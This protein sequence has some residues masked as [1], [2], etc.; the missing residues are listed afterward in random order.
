MRKKTVSSLLVIC[1][2]FT[3]TLGAIPYNTFAFSDKNEIEIDNLEG[4]IYFGNTTLVTTPALYRLVAKSSEDITL[5]YDGANIAEQEMKYDESNHNAWKDSYICNWLNGTGFI[6]KE[7][8]FTKAEKDSIIPYGE[9]EVTYEQTIDIS[10]KIVLPSYE[11]VN[12]GGAWRMNTSVRNKHGLEW[13]LRTPNKDNSIAALAVFVDGGI[14]F[15]DGLVANEYG[16]C[17]A[18][19]LKKDS[20]LLTSEAEGGKSELAKPVLETVSAANSPQKLTIIDSYDENA[21]P[22]GLK[23]GDVVVNGA[24]SNAGTAVKVTLTE[25]SS[26]KS[27]SA[28]VKNNS[29]E[30]THYGKIGETDLNGSAKNLDLTLPVNIGAGGNTLEIFVEEIN[31]AYK[32]DYASTP[33]AIEKIIPTKTKSSTSTKEESY[34]VEV[35]KTKGGNI[36]EKSLEYSNGTIKIYSILPDEGY[37]IKDVIIDN[38]SVGVVKEFRFSDFSSRHSIEAI[39][40]VENKNSQTEIKNKIQ[41]EF[42]YKNKFKDVKESDWF[43]NAVMNLSNLGLMNGTT[44]VSFEPKTKTTKAMALTILYNMSGRPAIKTSG[45]KW[46]SVPQT[47]AVVNGISDGLNMEDGISREQLITL[48]WRLEG[49]PTI[50]NYEGLM[51]F[52]DLDKISPY[53]KAAFIWAHHNGII[54]GSQDKLSPKANATRAETAAII[55]NYIKQK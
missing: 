4:N 5:F 52:K 2:L 41:N 54:S 6:D 49:S 7:G 1:M 9:T 39:F 31:E 18:F 40:E 34:P 36:L 19:K 35:K 43:Y 3:L 42:Q 13:W 37:E 8:V 11:E 48:I 12:D 22:E 20:I 17:P 50:E 14:S 28:I 55:F 10:Q 51:K 32:T 46:Y 21:N 44:E 16:I 38:K 53:A 45:N 27:V 25:A 33:L 47:W 29:G 24:N 30:I 26:N 15:G 23:S